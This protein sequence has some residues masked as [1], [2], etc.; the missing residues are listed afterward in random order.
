[1]VL[2]NYIDDLIIYY[3]L[4]MIYYLFNWF[5]IESISSDVWIALEFSSYALCVTIIFTISSAIWTFEA[6]IQDCLIVL[7]DN[8]SISSSVIASP[9][10]SV[11]WYNFSPKLSR[12][13]TL[14]NCTILKFWSSPTDLFFNFFFHLCLCSCV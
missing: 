4:I 13:K 3:I 2:G 8:V 14:V 9:L 6:S 7:L 12:P 5:A 1:M 10:A 11:V